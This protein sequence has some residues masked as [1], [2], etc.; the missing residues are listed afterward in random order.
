MSTQDLLQIELAKQEVAFEQHEKETK[1][2]TH[3]DEVWQKLHFRLMKPPYNLKADEIIYYTMLL[4]R[5]QLSKMPSN[6]AKYTDKDN[7][8]YCIYSREQVMED[9]QISQNTATALMKRVVKKGF[10]KTKRGF[11]HTKLYP[12]PLEK[13]WREFKTE[14]RKF[15][16][17]GK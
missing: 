3:Q 8:V 11:N 7:E 10:L 9:F 4:R 13:V 17:E 15:T 6:V 12:L 5:M 16:K 2:L 1:K 14:D